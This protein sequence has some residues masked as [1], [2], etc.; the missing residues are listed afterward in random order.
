MRR[1][2]FHGS[3]VETLLNTL[4][5]IN[6]EEERRPFSIS[7]FVHTIYDLTDPLSY[8][9]IKDNQL[10]MLIFTDNL[11]YCGHVEQ[12][13]K[14]AEFQ[15]VY[16]RYG[17]MLRCPVSFYH[18]VLRTSLTAVVISTTSEGILRI[19]AKY[20]LDLYKDGSIVFSS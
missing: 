6:R 2:I 8:E 20:L 19:L 1:I 18:T 17:R 7:S 11:V 10:P 3:E 16:P 4:L 9:H 13:G 5:Y 15:Q 12:F 14:Y